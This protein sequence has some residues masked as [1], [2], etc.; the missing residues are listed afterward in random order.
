MRGRLAFL[1]IGRYGLRIKTFRSA[2]TPH[3]TL[4]V[5]LT[6]EISLRHQLIVDTRAESAGGRERLRAVA[7]GSS[8]GRPHSMGRTAEFVQTF[9]CEQP[10]L[11]R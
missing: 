1:G 5:E 6:N 2:G 9:V 3:A 8:A 4:N 7:L 11:A 10:L